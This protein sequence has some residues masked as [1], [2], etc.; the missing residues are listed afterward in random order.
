MWQLSLGMCGNRLTRLWECCQEVQSHRVK[1]CAYKPSKTTIKRLHWSGNEKASS[2]RNPP[3]T[4]RYTEDDLKLIS[5][6]LS[7]NPSRLLCYYI[8]MTFLYISGL[9]LTQSQYAHQ[10]KVESFRGLIFSS[11][12][13]HL[14]IISQVIR[15][16]IPCESFSYKVH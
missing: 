2:S 5:R 9:K 3:S 16:Y 14:I 1:V 10:K 4:V 8:F 7:I 15:L 11:D 13:H 12:E 6:I